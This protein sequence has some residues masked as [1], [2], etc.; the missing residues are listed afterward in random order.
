M[1][2]Q[3]AGLFQA[4]FLPGLRLWD[5]SHEEGPALQPGGGGVCSRAAAQ[6]AVLAALH[7]EGCL[8]PCF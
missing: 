5:V 4:V 6:P 8:P 3:K 2:S 1:L 7:V